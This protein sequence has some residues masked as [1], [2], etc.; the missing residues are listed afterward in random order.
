[1]H[2]ILKRTGT[3]SVNQYKSVEM[4][5]ISEKPVACDTGPE[6][7]KNFTTF[8][9]H[10]YHEP[11]YYTFTKGKFAG[12]DNVVVSATGYTGSG[13]VEIYFEDKMAPPIKYG[14]L[15]SRSVH[16]RD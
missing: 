12:V 15:F 13:G 9:G 5:N 10:R 11:Q 3:G 8:S 2:L 14:M 16:H 7:N 4:H 1:M 6:R